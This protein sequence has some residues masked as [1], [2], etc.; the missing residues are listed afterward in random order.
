MDDTLQS[1]D[2]YPA[3]VCRTTRPPSLRLYRSDGPPRRCGGRSPP[4]PSS[5]LHFAMYPNVCFTPSSTVH[6]RLCAPNRVTSLHRHER[7]TGPTADPLR[8]TA[9]AVVRPRPNPYSRSMRPPPFTTRCKYACKK[10]AVPLGVVAEAPQPVLGS[11]PKNVRNA[12]AT[13][14]CS[15]RRR[16]HVPRRVLVQAAL[17]D[18]AQLRAPPPGKSGSRCAAAGSRQPG[19]SRAGTPG[20]EFRVA[21]P[22]HR[23]GST[24][25]RTRASSN[26][27]ANW[28]DAC[29][30]RESTHPAPR[31]CRPLRWRASGPFLPVV[32]ARSGAQRV[33]QPR[34]AL[35]LRPHRIHAA[36]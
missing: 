36:A 21:P 35:G 6:A 23:I 13:S 4:C 7:S 3:P 22:P 2:D 30:A 11:S 1:P 29:A 20:R 10:A 31:R 32:E 15:S 9:P 26:L 19:P 24:T 25:R 34:L 5:A 12:S 8:A 28:S 33:H 16:R 14:S 17:Q 27:C 18:E